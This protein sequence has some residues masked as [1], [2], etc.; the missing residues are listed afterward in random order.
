MLQNVPRVQT[1]SG[2][3]GFGYNATLTWNKLQSILKLPMLLTLNEFNLFLTHCMF[4]PLLNYYS[5]LLF[6]FC[7]LM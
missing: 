3:K 2:K 6:V 7:V 1:E 5:D 4:Y